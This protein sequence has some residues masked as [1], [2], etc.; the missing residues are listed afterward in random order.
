MATE[1]MT[2]LVCRNCSE[3]IEVS[4]W[5]AEE[6]DV[7]DLVR[8]VEHL[9]ECGDQSFRRVLNWRFEEVMPDDQ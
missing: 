8:L 7:D 2:R 6:V 3:Q 5:P 1:T 4:A 9:V